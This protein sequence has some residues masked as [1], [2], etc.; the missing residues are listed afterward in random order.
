MGFDQPYLYDS[1]RR[2]LRFPEKDFDP[3]AVTRASWE[4]K[5]RTEKRH[6]PLVSF[7]R[8]PDAH[9]V[10]T[11]RT[12][13]FRPMSSTTKWWIR[14]TRYVQLLLRTLEMAGGAGLLTLMILIDKVDPL[15]SWVM[16]IT[17]GV[18][19]ATSAYAILHLAR[20]ARARPPMSSAAY[21][22]FAAFTDLAVLPLYGF[23]LI[24]VTNQGTEWTTTLSDASLAKPLVEAEYY[25]LFGAGAL[26]VFSLC[27]S[28][29]LGWQFRRIAKMPPDMNPLED[30]LTS[31]GTKKHK[32]NKSSVASG[33]TA[34]SEGAKRLSDPLESHRRSGAPY[35]DLSRP[36]SIPFMNTRSGSSPRSSLASPSK[37]RDSAVELPGRHYQITPGNS[38]R[39]SLASAAD[40]RRMST[41]RLAARGSYTE[42]PIH[43][44]G[45]PSSPSPSRPGSVI[46]SCVAPPLPPGAPTSASPA[47]LARFTEAWYASESLIQRTQQRQRAQQNAPQQQ[48]QGSLPSYE[49]VGRRYNLDDDDDD[50]ES[51]Y[52]DRDDGNNDMRPD[53]DLEEDDGDDR[54]MYDRPMHPN[55]LFSNPLPPTPSPP[56]RAAPRQKT[57]FRPRK[58]FGGGA[59]GL[60]SRILGGLSPN[61]RSA[62]GGSSRDIADESLATAT[63]KVGRG[64]GYRDSSIQPEAHFYSRPYGELKA[65]TP[66]IMLTTGGSGSGDGGRRQVSTGHD[67]YYHGGDSGDLG[68]AAG[69]RSRN[70]SGKVAEE[71]RGGPAAYSRYSVLNGM[72]DVGL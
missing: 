7:N 33:Y 39:N 4:P 50:D 25:A 64:G 13:D 27:I 56:P 72:T 60:G 5:P 51:D 1:D 30:H 18:I 37:K 8:H 3:K 36:P 53:S 24:S 59:G 54:K 66:P 57:P 34:V 23:G 32:R 43:E 2:D 47:R 48:Q 16:R 49:A 68:A 12:Y 55:P 45:S 63:A 10:P 71:G 69:V 42:I 61:A 38:P 11:G 40:L 19:I 28:V 26:H 65:A 6:G 58:S 67:H 46:S 41:P 14:W 35:E 29:W 22:L 20:P 70:V 17:P 44:T 21:Q 15:T 31:R 9:E 52:S 62:S